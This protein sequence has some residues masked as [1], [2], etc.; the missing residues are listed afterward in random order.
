M[1]PY[2]TTAKPT[3]PKAIYTYVCGEWLSACNNTKRK[4]NVLQ[5]KI[6]KLKIDC[7]KHHCYNK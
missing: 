6:A 7:R 4:K 3:I 5:A 2:K 1:V